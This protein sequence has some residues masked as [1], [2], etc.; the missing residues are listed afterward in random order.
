MNSNSTINSSSSSRSS[1]ESSTFALYYRNPAARQRIMDV[2]NHPNDN[3]NNNDQDDTIRGNTYYHP[4]H[5]KHTDDTID[6]NSDGGN[7]ND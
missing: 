1:Q 5:F 7:D 3:T 6:I 4:K 2:A